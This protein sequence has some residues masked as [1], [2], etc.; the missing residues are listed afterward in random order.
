MIPAHLFQTLYKP[1]FTKFKKK[2]KK[3]MFW[4]Y[5]VNILTPVKD[6]TD[7]PYDQQVTDSY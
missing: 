7:K 2:K 4:Q 5:K 3:L 6:K 1:E